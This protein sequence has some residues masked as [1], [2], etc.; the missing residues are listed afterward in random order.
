MDNM[1]YNQIIMIFVW[2]FCILDFADLC[3]LIDLSYFNQDDDIII[4]V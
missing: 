1:E 2:P 3:L 4:N